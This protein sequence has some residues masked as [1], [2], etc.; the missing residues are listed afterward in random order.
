MVDGAPNLVPIPYKYT[1]WL[2][3]YPGRGRSHTI[4]DS[5]AKEENCP[6]ISDILLAPGL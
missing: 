6:I 3:G 1:H 4:P 5:I 2:S